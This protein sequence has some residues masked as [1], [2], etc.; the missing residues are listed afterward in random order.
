M[1]ASG[2]LKGPNWLERKPRPMIE[3]I[4]IS[5]MILRRLPLRL[6]CAATLSL[7]NRLSES[8]MK[9]EHWWPVVPLVTATGRT[10]WASG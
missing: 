2:A 6:N 10:W 9:P 5:L 4:M 8:V 1:V 3:A 7:T